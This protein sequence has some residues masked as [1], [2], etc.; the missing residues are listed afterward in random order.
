METPPQADEFLDE[1][2][3]ERAEEIADE[4]NT[5][6]HWSRYF[7]YMVRTIQHRLLLVFSATSRSSSSGSGSS[8]TDG[9]GG[10]NSVD[11][12]DGRS[13]ETFKTVVEPFGVSRHTD[14]GALTVLLQVLPYM[15]GM[16]WSTTSSDD[17]VLR[18]YNNSP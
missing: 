9:D 11:V 14:S 2:I 12:G 4:V 10:G 1:D 13:G 5:K 7:F 15:D 3:D 6:V 18:Y 17:D 16:R 8:S